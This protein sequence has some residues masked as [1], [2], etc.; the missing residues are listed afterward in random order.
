MSEAL[1][2]RGVHRAF[3][4]AAGSRRLEVL[5]GVELTIH[6]GEIVALVG[7]SGA[8]KSTLLHIAGLLEKPDSGQVVLDGRDY[9]QAGEA[10]R[11]RA[12]RAYLG[13]VYQFHHLLPEFSAVENIVLPQMIAG[14]SRRQ[15]ARGPWTCCA[16]WV[17]S[18]RHHRPAKLSGG[19][20]QRV[21]IA[22][23]IA[24]VPRLLLADEP[25]GNW[26]PA[27]P[28]MFSSNCGASPRPPAWPLWW[29]RTTLTWPARWTAC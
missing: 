9:S 15:A 10:A 4:E 11:T 8:G 19:E 28:A 3:P 26:T 22:R 24:N 20:Q 5:R 16:W 25:T 1:A 14:L 18:A 6:T 27:P 29:R 12:R 23:A 21:A 17:G 2:L 7:P 13:F